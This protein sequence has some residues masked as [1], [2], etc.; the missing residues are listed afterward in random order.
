MKRVESMRKRMTVFLAIGIICL[1]SG[2]VMLKLHVAPMVIPVTMCGIGGACVTLYFLAMFATIQDEMVKRID[3][4]SGSYSFITTL[5]FIFILG[6]I[7]HFYSLPWSID[8]LLLAMMLFMC[9][10]F[11]IIRHY[12]LRLGK[13]E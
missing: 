8:N 6:I 10:S 1:I 3:V 11:I 7:N 13:T 12:L 5:Y 4:L 9:I 2:F